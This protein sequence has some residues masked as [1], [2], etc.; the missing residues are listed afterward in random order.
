MGLQELDV[1]VEV[2]GVVRD[3]I[4]GKDAIVL[5]STDFSHYIPKAEAARRDRK[6]IDRILASDVKGFY[7]TIKDED[8]SMCGYGPVIA[9]M[10]AIAPATPELLKYASSGDVAA[11]E[12]VVGY[13]AIAFRR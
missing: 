6:A 11:M 12:D 10:T 1:A 13:G 7:R 4:K 5:A 9:M 8:V 2:G 3:A